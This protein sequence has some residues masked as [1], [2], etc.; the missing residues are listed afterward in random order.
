[1]GFMGSGR[2]RL[3]RVVEGKKGATIQREGEG[4]RERELKRRGRRGN[5]LNGISSSV[6]Y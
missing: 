2:R 6:I 3:I 1:M 4:S 5:F